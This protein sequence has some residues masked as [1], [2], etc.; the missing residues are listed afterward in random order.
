MDA[1]IKQSETTLWVTADVLYL[2]DGIGRCTC[3]NCHCNI[4]LQD[5]YCRHCGGR[6]GGR[7]W[8]K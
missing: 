6:I 3:S 4:E 2:N 1:D 7:R 8:K 5:N